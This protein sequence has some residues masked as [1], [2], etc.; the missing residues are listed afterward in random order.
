MMVQ[1]TLVHGASL[2]YS[3]RGCMSGLRR[4]LPSYRRN[5]R[6]ASMRCRPEVGGNEPLVLATV[7]IRAGKG[8]GGGSIA[9]AK[10]KRCR[11]PAAR[12]GPGVE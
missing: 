8:T 5:D 6:W 3:Y 1:T 7:P 9:A 11:L 10:R 2:P 12:R 4:L